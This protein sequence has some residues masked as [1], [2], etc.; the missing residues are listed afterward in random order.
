MDGIG[1]YFFAHFL[2]AF[3]ISLPTEY[4]ILKQP[5]PKVKIASTTTRISTW[6]PSFQRSEGFHKIPLNEG[7]TA[8][9]YGSILKFSIKKMHDISIKNITHLR[10]LTV[11]TLKS[12]VNI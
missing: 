2:L 3:A 12:N 10:F 8:Y 1:G 7:Q 11:Y 5:N 4:P 9:R 6:H